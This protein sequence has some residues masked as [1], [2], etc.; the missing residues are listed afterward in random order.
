MGRTAEELFNE[1]KARI[2]AETRI[3][4]MRPGSI[5]RAILK[6]HGDQLNELYQY[7]DARMLNA[8]VSTA[9]GRFLDELGKLVGAEREG[10]RFA[11]GEV[12]FYV[13]PDLG[14]SFQS[15]LDLVNDRTGGSAT[16]ITIP[17]GTT[18]RSGNRSYV[19][20]TDA[21]LQSGTTEVTVTV[22]CTLAG[23]FGNVDAGGISTIVWPDSVLSVLEGVVLVTNDEPVESGRDIQSDEDFR[24]MIVNSYL[25]GA[26]ANET[27][28][29]LAVLSVPGVTD[30]SF[31][32]YAYG[33]GTFA[34]YVTAS[35]PVVTQGTLA[36]AQ[37]AINNTQA[38]GARGVAVS[39]DLIGVQTKIALVFLPT[40]RAADK[41]SITTDVQN[42]VIDYINNLKAG[43]TMVINEITQRVMD[44]STFIHDSQIVTVST[45][46]YDLDTGLIQNVDNTISVTNQ[47]PG[48]REKFVTNRNLC[49][50]CHV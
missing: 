32:N 47:T 41:T 40:T 36:A 18:V 8:Y 24:F 35:S 13:N 16:V 22:L 21:I 2:L 7:V 19:T 43:E 34:V 31:Q 4:N 17:A 25:F 20:N 27:A 29:R 23:S 3:S 30:I 6:T 28:I 50:V 9:T 33:I 12:R 15:V 42:A 37:S 39:P 46:D 48:V 44:V 14:M 11:Q 5:A 1:A 26:K 38:K 45:G 10:S 49:E